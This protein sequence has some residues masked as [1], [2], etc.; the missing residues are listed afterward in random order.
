MDSAT[1]PTTTTKSENSLSLPIA[2]I[3]AGALIAGAIYLSQTSKSVTPTSTTTQAANTIT[4]QAITANDHFLG[5][6]NASITLIEFSDLECPYCK[7]FHATMNTL[8]DEYGKNGT[9]AWVYRHFPLAQ[10][11]PTAPRKSEAVECVDE[12]SNKTATWN[13]INR[14]F[15]ETPQ[16]GKLEDTQMFTI[17]GQLGIKKDALTACLDSGKYTQKVSSQLEDAVKAGGRGTPFSVLMLKNE[18]SK[19]D[20]EAILQQ[21]ALFGAT[22]LIVVD[23]SKKI[24]SLSGALPIDFMKQLI[25]TL[26]Q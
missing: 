4:V 24:V 26:T 25:T 3:V 19:A 18:I 17:A 21:A 11:H 16:G 7:V 13:F 1:S 5:N 9:L 22:N 10:L 8:M 20:E 6:P 14:L 15:V 2:I 12:L 23:K